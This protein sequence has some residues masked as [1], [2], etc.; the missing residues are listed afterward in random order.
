MAWHDLADAFF[1]QFAVT[2][3]SSTG[4]VVLQRVPGPGPFKQLWASRFFGSAVASA[5]P[6][7][8]IVY[9]MSGAVPRQAE[10]HR[11]VVDFLTPRL[12]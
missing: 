3:G 10:M 2:G 1:P 11:A 6:T 7:R 12:A 5:T 8:P 9:W 4:P